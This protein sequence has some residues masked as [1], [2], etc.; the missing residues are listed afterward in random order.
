[1]ITNIKPEIPYIVQNP[2]QVGLK[3]KFVYYNVS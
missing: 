2:E 3:T 1:V